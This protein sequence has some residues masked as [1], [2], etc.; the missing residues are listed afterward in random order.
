[1]TLI[2]VPVAGA[3]GYAWYFG[4]QADGS[5]VRL[6]QVTTTNSATITATSGNTAQLIT[7]LAATNNSVNSTVYDGMLAQIMKSGSGAYTADL[8]PL[9]GGARLTTDGAGGITELNTAFASFWDNYRLSPQEIYVGSQVL[10][11][12]NGII[13]KNG[14]APLIRYNMDMPGGGTLDAG[15]VVGTVLNKIT[16]Q[17]VKINIHPNMPPGMLMFWSD[18]VPYPLNDIGA[19]VLKHL[20]RDYYQIEWPLVTRSYQYGVYFDGVLKNYFPPAFGL[21]RGILPGF[22]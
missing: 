20:R 9:L 12:M 22:A 19:I 11:D 8:S 16:N 6:N 7:A 14:G 13:V 3:V 4:T 2:V 21:I 15:I 5:D 1:M 18:S 10:M 17:K